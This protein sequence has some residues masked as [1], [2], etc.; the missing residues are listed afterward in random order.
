MDIMCNDMPSFTVDHQMDPTLAIMLT[1]VKHVVIDT[2]ELT[3]FGVISQLNLLYIT[4][5]EHL[6]LCQYDAANVSPGFYSHMTDY[7]TRI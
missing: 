7:I 2:E 3:L 6:A 4:G 5:N 1:L